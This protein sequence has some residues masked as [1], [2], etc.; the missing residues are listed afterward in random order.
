MTQRIEDLRMIVR[1]RERD[2]EKCEQAMEA[3]R[4]EA[5]RAET[6]ARAASDALSRALASHDRALADRRETPA[7][8]HVQLH[9][10][11]C[12]AQCA[13][14]RDNRDEADAALVEACAEVE[15]RSTEWRRAQ[16]RRDVLTEELRKAL[17]AVKR[18][19][20]RRL[21]EETGSGARRT[22]ALS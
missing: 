13:A 20:A 22:M 21:D 16:M 19:I 11:T 10:Q 17:R 12:E 15:Q 8:P 9:C 14:R 2:V 18:Q 4:A 1:L 3:A 6:A 5:C 7:N